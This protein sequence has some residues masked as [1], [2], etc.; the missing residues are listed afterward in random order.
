MRLCLLSSLSV[1][2]AVFISASA[3]AA[4]LNNI[5]QITAT[6]S[7]SKSSSSV[8]T[9]PSKKA[10]S[11][12]NDNSL[13]RQ[14]GLSN[15]H[16]S[17]LLMR[18]NNMRGLRVERIKQEFNGTPIWGQQIVAHYGST[19]NV[20][21]LRGNYASGL[22]AELPTNFTSAIIALDALAIVKRS[23]KI[24]GVDVSVS[25]ESV[26]NYI[27][28][29][30]VGN[31]R[32]VFYVK[33]FAQ[34]SDGVPSKPNALVDANTGEII[35]SWNGLPHFDGTGPGGNEKTGRY[36]YGI[37]YGFLDVQQSGST[38]VLENDDV[39]SIGSSR[40]S[41][42]AAHEYDCPRNIFEE[43]NG[44]Y[45]PIN[46]GHYFGTATF[47][48]YRDWAGVAPLDA[49]LKIRVHYGRNYQNAFWDEG[50][51]FFGDGGNRYH[52][53][54]V[55][56][57]VAHEVSHGFTQQNSGLLYRYQSGGINEAFSDMAGEAL[58]YYLTGTNDWLFA[59]D[60]FKGEGQLRNMFN[61]S[62][63]GK[64]IDH[65]ENYRNGMDVHH[66][67]GVF[68]KAFY[69]L[70]ITDGWDTKRAFQI[71]A[72]ANQD[73]WTPNETFN[74]A[75]C[76]I[77]HA[78]IDLA[79]NPSE[80]AAAFGQVGVSCS[81]PPAKDS[82]VDGMTDYWELTFGFDP[83][84]PSDANDDADIDGLSNLGEFQY[85]SNPL[86]DD[87]DNDG[88][89]D[90]YEAN[91]GLAIGFNDAALD[92][93]GDGRTNLQEFELGSNSQIDDVFPVLSIPADIT[94]EAIGVQTNVDLGVGS[95]VDGKDGVIIPTID[96][97]GPFY[98]GVTLITWSASDAAGNMSAQVQRVN[99]VPLVSFSV[100]K[101]IEE[102]GSAIVEAILNG[103]PVS[104]PVTVPYTVSGSASYLDDHDLVDGVISI[105]SGRVASATIAASTDSL[106]EGNESV[107]V[108]MG[109]PTNA[110]TGSLTS[111]VITI[112][113]DNIAP[114]ADFE[115]MQNGDRV[116]TV[117]VDGGLV[118]AI[119]T[120]DDANTDDG[121]SAVW[122]LVGNGVSSGYSGGTYI[123]DPLSLAVGI[124]RLQLIV[125][126]DGNGLL[127][128]SVDRLIKV[129]SSSTELSIAIDSDEDGV[130]DADEGDVDLDG[131]RIPDYLD[132]KQ[133]A[134][135][136][137][138]RNGLIQTDMG[139]RLLL[140]DTAYAISS[141]TAD[142]SLADIA[143]SGGLDGGAA[144][145][146]VDI[147]YRPPGIYDFEVYT[148]TAG[149][150]V[151]VVIP[152]QSAILSNMVYRKYYADIGWFNFTENSVNGVE[153]ALGS[154]G[155]C[156]APGHSSYIEGLNAGDY[157]LQLTIEDGG[158]N[159]LD[160]IANGIVKD[161]GGLALSSTIK[162]SVSIIRGNTKASFNAGG[163]EQ[164]VLRFSVN[165]DST[166]GIIESITVKGAGGINETSDISVVA[167]YHDNNLNG[168]PDAA[169]KVATGTYGS[170][171][172]TVTLM[173]S[174]AVQLIVGRSDFLITYGF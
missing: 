126:D 41:E 108:T 109:V 146:V 20:R 71:M 139:N 147:Y 100:E 130:S 52:S 85:D 31:S 17:K 124:Y 83:S 64:S 119:A 106:F 57:I 163:G 88:I 51:A 103:D 56:D 28:I 143:A 32:Y 18:R 158:P 159:D 172:G 110:V 107:V 34:D 155:V 170:D 2:I 150:A 79:Y 12:S 134:H 76:G 153:S 9:P 82:D 164:V 173:F 144:S 38:C 152:L 25:N 149:K 125:T 111:H 91:N 7:L 142:L 97:L 140:G 104:Y 162:P 69:L 116:A 118:S 135:L 161:P 81:N 132:A 157:C 21:K 141:S 29:N 167:V 95:A 66:S 47:A 169:E 131:N 22:D 171:N 67:S 30:N 46:D 6:T 74:T 102:G 4:T 133:D 154:L 19:G 14:L 128:G 123:I 65:L 145:D 16:N 3:N 36:E 117:A 138:T 93:D 148:K 89:T 49:Q 62:S 58:K 160:G 101:T 80:V 120:V 73:Y 129:T 115:L 84:D 99:I 151:R 114:L 127:S 112:T 72:L 92:A 26:A 10:S 50:T 166:D 55:L 122:T 105:N 60:A 42:G 24:D 87:T 45:S 63:D 61:P 5:E 96:K 11:V 48:M 54:A 35:E 174:S 94:V 40:F 121:H 137:P 1:V 113:E 86:Q 39:I 98:P 23:Q 59:K 15:Q 37:D 68:N 75:I 13:F 156:P 8:S 70:A 27:Y 168:L 53:F 43:V 44:A 78:T 33:Y 77:L 165:S 90:G 136:L